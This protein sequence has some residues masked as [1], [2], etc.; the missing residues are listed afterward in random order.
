M[1]RGAP[2]IKVFAI[3]AIAIGL[4]AGS[5]AAL[6]IPT[7]SEG[8]GGFGPITVLPARKHVI[9]SGMVQLAL[10]PGSLRIEARR[11]DPRG[12]PPFAVR[13]FRAQRLA[14]PPGGRD[15][16]KARLLGHPLCAQLGRIYRGRFGW[17]DARNRFRPARIDMFSAPTVCGD[18]WRDRRSLPQLTLTKLITDPLKSSAVPVQTVAW[19]FAGGLT[20]SV[21]L[22]GVPAGEQSP[23]SSQRG[24]FLAF[25]DDHTRSFE[26]TATVHYRGRS[27]LVKV[28]FAG[29]WG[30]G[31]P[32]PHGPLEQ[33]VIPG[34]QQIEAR[35]PDPSGGLP[36]AMTASRSRGGDW[37][38]ASPGRLVGTLVGGVAF[39]LGTFSESAPP[40]HCFSSGVA[41]SHSMP[42]AISSG[43]SSI[44]YGLDPEAEPDN[45][46]VRLR[47]LR[48][49]TTLGGVTSPDVREVTIKSPRDV[50]TVLPSPRAHVFLVVY[51][52]LFPTGDFVLTSTFADGS[53][54]TQK[55][56]A[57]F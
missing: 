24:A 49:Q 41:L 14:L 19:G 17:L 57:G 38:A 2:S 1:R 32:P 55:V 47:T 33:R 27:T 35:A 31:A 56:R 29:R 36:W 16:S 7:R 25:G 50:R 51:D 43:G 39:N 15:L 52:G 11:A 42:I 48:G 8:K 20:S 34:T 44:P 53:H 6:V 26:A 28:P 30:A 13:V 54:A 9:D 10:V 3:T 37:C 22:D 12:G 18:R 45:G 40:S 21:S 4:I 5:I 46:R 23:K